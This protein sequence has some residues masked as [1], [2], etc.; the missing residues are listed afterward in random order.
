ARRGS[1]QAVDA[2]PPDSDP[3]VVVRRA[4][5]DGAEHPRRYLDPAKSRPH[6]HAE[7][8]RSLAEEAMKTKPDAADLDDIQGLV[9]TGWGEHEYAG[10]LFAT[11]ADMARARAWLDSARRQVSPASLSRTGPGD[12]LNIALSP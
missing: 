2:P 11:L 6:A 4:R 12:R 9:Y 3:G 10:Y 1:V 8:A 5:F 7:R